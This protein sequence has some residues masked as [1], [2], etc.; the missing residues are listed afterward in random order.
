ME[1]SEQKCHN[2]IHNLIG[3]FSNFVEN[4]LYESG[5]SVETGIPGIIPYWFNK[6]GGRKKKWQAVKVVRNICV[7]VCFLK[8]VKYS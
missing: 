6:T 7:N 2:L 1:N 5:A 8:Q 4:R 3:S